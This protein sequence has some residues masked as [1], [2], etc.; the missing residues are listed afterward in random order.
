M[1][2]DPRRK[3]VQ[4]VCSIIATT[5]MQHD[6]PYHILAYYYYASGK[7]YTLFYNGIHIFCLRDFNEL[8][9]RYYMAEQLI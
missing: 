2:F 7:G 9:L 1:D 3:P 6:N 5:S 4:Y 8:L